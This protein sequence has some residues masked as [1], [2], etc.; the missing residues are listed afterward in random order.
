RQRRRGPGRESDAGVITAADEKGRDADGDRRRDEVPGHDPRIELRPHGDAAD[1]G[2]DRNDG[3][4]TGVEP[5]QAGAVRAAGPQH[6]GDADTE[7]GQDHGDEPVAEL[8]VAVD[9]HRRGGHERIRGALG[10]IRAAEPGAGEPDDAA[11][12]DDSRL[13][14]EHGPGGDADLLRDHFTPHSKRNHLRAASVPTSPQIRSTMI[15][16]MS[17][18]PTPMAERITSPSAPEGR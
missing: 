5:E 2:P 14:D 18:P 15:A 11:A 9:A 8:D 16:L 7:D 3:E 13:R 17:M 4:H 1:H 10:P 6:E 12:Q